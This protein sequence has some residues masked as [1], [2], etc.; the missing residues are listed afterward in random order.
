M[1]SSVHH[2]G[3]LVENIE[4]ATLTYTNLFPG[5]IV[6]KTFEIEEQRVY[7]KFVQVANLHIELVQPIDEQSTLFR[8]LKKN[9]GFYHIG[10][11]TGNMDAEIER[12]VQLGYR[13]LNKFK[14]AAFENR[15][16]AFLYTPEMHLIELIE[17]AL[18][19]EL[20]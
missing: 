17:E 7:V 6:S 14:S 8:I 3:C 9:P 13:K 18:T 16:C 20:A 2:I 15:H 11:F 12:L 10:I 1:I 4:D 19:P 5:G